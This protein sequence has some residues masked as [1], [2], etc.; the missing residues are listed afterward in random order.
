MEIEKIARYLKALGD[1]KR[2]QLLAL[3]KDGVQCNCEFA[4]H[5]SLQPNLISHHLSILRKAGLVN[6]VKDPLDSRWIY[7]TINQDSFKDLRSYLN[8]FLD[9]ATIQPRAP[10]CGPQNVSVVITEKLS[11]QN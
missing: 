10:S 8:Q 5:L 11:I 2:L 1:P 3:I 7:Y 6:F 9:P 4:D